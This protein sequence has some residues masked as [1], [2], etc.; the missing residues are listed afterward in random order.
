M[1]SPDIRML[2]LPAVIQRIGVARSTLYDWINPKSPRYDPTFP[3]QK[4]LGR[5]S[6][7]W[8]ES[9]VNDWL[10]NRQSV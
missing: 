6:V 3:K 1:S 9:E 4:R 5:Q 2:R 7:G 10:L 8:V